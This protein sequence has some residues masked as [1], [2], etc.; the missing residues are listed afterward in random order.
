MLLF[1]GFVQPR[2]S[3]MIG[4]GKLSGLIIL[5]LTAFLLNACGTPAEPE[6]VKTPRI[7]APKPYLGYDIKSFDLEGKTVLLL[8]TDLI[9][10]ANS[11]DFKDSATNYLNDVLFI[12]KKYPDQNIH[13]D[14]STDPV[15]GEKANEKLALKQAATFAGFLWSSGITPGKSNRTLTFS[16][17]AQNNPIATNKNYVGKALN[18]RIMVTIYPQGSNFYFGNKRPQ[19]KLYGF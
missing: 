16:A 10:E 19:E 4:K 13:I 15:A 11:A 18:R 9:F 5:I 7:P 2:V 1:I 17:R 3:I 6:Y 8:S 12:L 14:V